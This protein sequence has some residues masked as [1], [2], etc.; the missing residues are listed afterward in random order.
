M[1]DFTAVSIIFIALHLLSTLGRPSR[2]LIP[3]IPLPQ[4]GIFE[5]Q[6]QGRS[7]SSASL[8]FSPRMGVLSLSLC[9]VVRHP[10]A[11]DDQGRL[12]RLTVRRRT[13]GCSSPIST[14]KAIGP[15]R[16]T[17]QSRT[18]LDIDRTDKKAWA[19]GT[20][21]S[22]LVV[23]ACLVICALTGNIQSRAAVLPSPI[24]A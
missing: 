8:G 21:H 6:L 23:F 10:A 24:F 17:F 3:I 11:V 4:L 5:P 20:R 14:R 1:G 15:R 12:R 18:G 16:L 9:C 19:L 2:R 22:T 7:L 13:K